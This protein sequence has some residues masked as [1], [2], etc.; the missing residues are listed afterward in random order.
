M[1]FVTY[2]SSDGREVAG[3]LTTNDTRILPLHSFADGKNADLD[4]VQAVIE[5]GDESLERVRRILA[6]ADPQGAE[7]LPFGSSRLYR[8][9]CRSVTCSAFSITCETPRG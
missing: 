1:K 7:T 4:S 8:A 2:E 5:G 6:E 3:V 9:R